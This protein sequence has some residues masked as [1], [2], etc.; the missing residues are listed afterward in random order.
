MLMKRYNGKRRLSF[1]RVAV[2]IVAVTI[3]APIQTAKAFQPERASFTISLQELTSNLSILSTT[4]MPLGEVK[5][6]SEA[7][8]SASDG[9]LTRNG[10]DWVWQAPST[11][12]LSVLTFMQGGENIRLN[13]FVLTPWKNG[14]QTELNGYK[15]GSYEKTLFRGLASYAAPT[16]FIEVTPELLNTRV[17]PHF[18]LGQFLCK[19]QP[20]HNPSYVLIR[21][22]MLIKLEHLLEA[23]NARGWNAETFN[24][25]SGFRTPYYNRAI[26]NTTTSSRHLY[27][28]AADIFIDADGDGNMDD[29]NGDGKIN[30]ADAR[31]LA[32][33]ARDLSD[34]GVKDWRPGGIA[35]Y[36]ANSAHGPFVHVDVRGYRARWGK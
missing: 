10:K 15:I 19:Q 8:A 17:S 11:P 1:L 24:V 28:G 32:A 35:A 14:A 4:V 7:A 31:A 6:R 18:T 21:T 20:G 22:G 36:S 27:G 34:S 3:C 16:G 12:G 33:L 13:V 29:L 23:A 30:T 9:D 26:G 5:V 25:M 2:V